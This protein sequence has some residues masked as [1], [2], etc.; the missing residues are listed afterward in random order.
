MSPDQRFI[1]AGMTA[2]ATFS[3]L[4]VVGGQPRAC[5]RSIERPVLR[6]RRGQAALGFA[7]AGA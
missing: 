7:F 4:F 3:V 5:T 1:L 6:G 2:A